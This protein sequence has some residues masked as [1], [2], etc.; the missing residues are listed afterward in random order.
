MNYIFENYLGTIVNFFTII[1][2]GLLGALFKK[3]IPDRIVSS[4]N[5]AMATCAIYIGISGTL[6]QISGH[7][8]DSFLSAGLYKVLVMIVSMAVGT[9]IGELIDIDKWINRLGDYLG[10]KLSSDGSTFGKGFVTCSLISCI[11]AMAVNGAIADSLGEPDILFAKSI[12]DGVTVFVM[13]ASMGIGCAFSGF[14]VLVYQASITLFADLVLSALS[15]TVLTLMSA[16]GSLII[17]LV[18]LN[19]MGVTKVRTANMVPAIFCVP[20]VAWLLS[21]I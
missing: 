14:L 17:I 12:I 6:E 16:T 5:T 1:I 7:P 3:G 18:G 13:A 4:L 8:E 21:L 2:M 10:K 20:F 9:L 15:A 11:G 19:V